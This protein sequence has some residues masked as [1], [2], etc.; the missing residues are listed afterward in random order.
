S[1]GS[2]ASS[3]G[4]D[5][6][7]GVRSADLLVSPV[8]GFAVHAGESVD[9]VDAFGPVVREGVD[10]LLVAGQ[11]LDLGRVVTVADHL[12]AHPVALLRGGL[13]VVRQVAR[14]AGR[15]TDLPGVVGRFHEDVVRALHT[16]TRGSFRA[17]LHG[18]Q[19]TSGVPVR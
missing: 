2:D 19:L 4:P 10:V 17:R 5:A 18:A 16:G 3:K 1:H 13:Q 7:A 8:V 9:V 6:S 14:A 11:V 15:V 12:V